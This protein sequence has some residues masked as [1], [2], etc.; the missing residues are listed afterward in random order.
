MRRE[1]L[2]VYFSVR[3]VARESLPRGAGKRRGGGSREER[4][5]G[6][7]EVE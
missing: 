4:A 5:G 7:K 3:A 2:P 6:I 1:G